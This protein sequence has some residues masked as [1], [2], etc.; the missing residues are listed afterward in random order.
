MIYLC[1]D[2]VFVHQEKKDKNKNLLECDRCLGIFSRKDSLK[3][4]QNN[5]LGSQPICCSLCNLTFEDSIKLIDHIEL[6]HKPQNT[7]KLVH[8]FKQ[9]DQNNGENFLPYT[10]ESRKFKQQEE[11]LSKRRSVFKNYVI[12][13]NKVRDVSEILNDSM[14]EDVIENLHYEVSKN[15]RIKFS[16]YCHTVISK[17]TP[18]GTK[19][20]DNSGLISSADFRINYD[21][22]IRKVA[23]SSF[24]DLL[25]RSEQACIVFFIFDI[26]LVLISMFWLQFNVRG[27][28]WTIEMV[29][30]FDL[31]ISSLLGVKGGACLDLN[32][33]KDIIK[34]LGCLQ[35][36]GIR[37]IRD[38][39][40]KCLLNSIAAVAFDKE[41][42]EEHG[43]LYDKVI[44]DG[45]IYHK[46]Y[47][48]INTQGI[49]F[50][51]DE[52]DIYSLAR[53][54]PTYRITLYMQVG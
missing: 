53:Q 29:Q 49:E 3:R 14:L 23:E 35:K 34:V 5:C 22:D 1:R 2:T 47:K 54:N 25:A 31:R 27:S 48:R 6:L 42:K 40:E 12:I 7:F 52:N 37:S 33:S 18:E 36:K 8:E 11:E 32:Q 45:K 28:G 19:K 4:H 38:S 26:F 51:S 15:Y 16:F 41:I 44:K 30:R 24:K 10:E 43:L 20:Y 17:I 39:N 46:Y 50:P 21:S 9:A 13:F